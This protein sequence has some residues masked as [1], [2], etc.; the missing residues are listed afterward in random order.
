MAPN[1]A[2][3]LAVDSC[4][5]S[6]DHGFQHGRAAT[7]I[8]AAAQ[9]GAPGATDAAPFKREIITITTDIVKADIDTLGGELVRLELLKHH[10]KIDSKKNQVLFQ[11]GDKNTY[12][13][14]TGLVGAASPPNAAMQS[15]W[16]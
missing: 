5:A 10:D 4:A 7:A 1:M 14:Q 3:S 16:P 9:P 11:K 13:A 2:P 15:R 8:A 12:L 6:V